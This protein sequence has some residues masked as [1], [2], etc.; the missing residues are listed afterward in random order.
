MHLFWLRGN[1]GPKRPVVEVQIGCG[2][3]LLLDLAVI[4]STC[5]E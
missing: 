2:E 1:D 4:V 3:R 5:H